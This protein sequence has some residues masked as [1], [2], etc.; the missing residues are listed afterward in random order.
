MSK[1]ELE[2]D[3]TNVSTIKTL[4]PL[5][6]ARG[7]RSFLGHVGLKVVHKRLSKIVRLLCKFLEKDVVFAFDEACIE[8]FNEIKKIPLC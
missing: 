4:L 2:V 7:V 8:A 3:A 1:D 6:I 5:T